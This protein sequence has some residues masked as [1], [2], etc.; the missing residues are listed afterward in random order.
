MVDDAWTLIAAL[1]AELAELDRAI[2]GDG[3]QVP[4]PALV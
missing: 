4:A 1:E 2:C 3:P